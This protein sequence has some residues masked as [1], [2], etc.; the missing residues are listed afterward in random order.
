MSNASVSDKENNHPD[1][2]SDGFIVEDVRKSDENTRKR[3][4]SS[5]FSKHIRET[6][7]NEAVSYLLK[8]EDDSKN[9][10]LPH[11]VLDKVIEDLAENGCRVDR[12]HMNYRKR[13]ARSKLPTIIPEIDLELEEVV[14]SNVDDLNNDDTPIK[15]GRPAGK[16]MFSKKKELDLKIE[17]INEITKIYTEELLNRKLNNGRCKRSFLNDLIV[18]KWIEYELEGLVP[19]VP[20]ETIRNRFKK[21]V[22]ADCCHRGTPSPL[23]DIEDILVDIC[24]EMGSA[25]HPLTIL[26][27]I[28]LAND[29]IQG[30]YSQKLLEG[31][32]IKQNKNL[33][34]SD[35]QKVGY[36]WWEGFSRRHADR[37]ITKRGEKFASNRADWTKAPY[38]SQMYDRIYETFVKA[39]VAVKLDKPVS[40]DIQGN[41]VTEDLQYGLPCDTEI[42]HP[43]YILFADETGCNTN[44]KKDGHYGGT[45]YIVGRGTVPKEYAC[46][47]DKHFTLMGFTAANGEPVCCVL[48][49][50]GEKQD[51]PLYW[52]TGIDIKVVPVMD[53][54][55]NIAIDELNF[56]PGKFYPSGPSCKF[57][58]KTI[59][60]LPLISPSGGITGALLVEI[61][62]YL[63]KLEVFERTPDGPVPVLVVDGHDS[64]LDYDFITYIRNPKHR[65]Y[66]CV[67]VPYATALWQVGDSSQ[68]NGQFKQELNEA[69]RQ[70]VKFKT[71]KNLPT[72]MSNE[73]I[74]PLVNAAWTTSFGRVRSNKKAIAERGW[75]PPN[76]VLLLHK[77]IIINVTQNNETTRIPFASLT[78]DDN[79][80]Q[81]LPRI[82]NTS[83]GT[84]RVVL[85]T[86]LRYRARNGGV[87]Q[88]IANINRGQDILKDIDKGKRL[89][90][91]L[92]VARGVH[93]LNDPCVYQRLKSKK[94]NDLRIERKNK[95][96]LRDEKLILINAVKKLRTEK[97]D[98][99]KWNN[100]ECTLFIRY[101]RT[102]EDGVNPKTVSLLRERCYDYE[103]RNNSPTCS[104]EEDAASADMST[105]VDDDD[106][107]MLYDDDNAL[108]P[109]DENTEIV[110]V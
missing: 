77:D 92:L 5:S 37:L 93:S 68:Q 4:K 23:I 9:N 54:N 62:Q 11:G 26:E 83:T 44:Q 79:N 82:V 96:R 109:I 50:T 110:D 24:I 88:N 91:G 35:C 10:R 33:P 67:G 85:D 12:N 65:W 94:R 95:K 106:E 107:S 90:V 60:M 16:T 108:T 69:K 102:K 25:Y 87:E 74:V 21:G 86:L 78:R 34:A 14:D 81:N 66:V 22:K 49:F 17:C 18:S 80:E 13:V 27:T 63:D 41:V 97:V 100:K 19:R 53:E 6:A 103:K 52:S 3:S 39:R 7:I 8:Q 56:G 15:Y 64:R 58:G 59:P 101:K 76:R 43:D 28:K 1:D 48:I 31:M 99:N 2:D 36:G 30:T 72:T 20:A 104:D 32:K 89:T 71:E 57:R 105:D 45:K 46:T 29:M 51:I 42:L 75:F 98:I 84:V 40:N 61:L 73:D 55:S 70:L 38:I 47:T